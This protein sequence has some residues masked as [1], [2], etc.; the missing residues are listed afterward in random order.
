MCVSV[1]E[2]ER[3]TDREDKQEGDQ[4]I[5][6]MCVCT[7]IRVCICLGECVRKH[8]CLCEPGRY[9]S[10]SALSIYEPLFREGAGESDASCWWFFRVWC[11]AC[12][13]VRWDEWFRPSGSLSAPPK[14]AATSLSKNCSATSYSSLSP[15]L[16][17]YLYTHLMMRKTSREQPGS[18]FP[19]KLV[20]KSTWKP[21]VNK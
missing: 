9:F 19:T 8:V 11:A 14:A 2:R 10:L 3:K 21:I 16:L 1:S 15:L 20:R 6:E 7:Y 13:D 17:S 18:Y 12:I 4:E 5:K